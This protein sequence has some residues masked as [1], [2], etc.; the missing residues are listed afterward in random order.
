[1]NKNLVFLLSAIS[2]SMF[3]SSCEEDL[4]YDDDQYG[5]N[6][7]VVRSEIS[8]FFVR[9]IDYDQ[10]D[11]VIEV[12]TNG[13]G[14]EPERMTV[15]YNNNIA[16]ADFFRGG[17]L[18][19]SI[20]APL[21]EA[22]NVIESTATDAAGTEVAYQ[23][24]TYN[25]SDQI[26]SIAGRNAILNTEDSLVVVWTNDNATRFKR[27]VVPDVICDYYSGKEST[28]NVGLGNVIL[29]YMQVDGDIAQI[30]SKEL[31]KTYDLNGVI[32]GQ[33]IHFTYDLDSDDKVRK[34]FS[35]LSSG[36]PQQSTTIDYECE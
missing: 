5:S 27:Q 34:I 30:Y 8:D 7:M 12:S 16:F 29:L 14:M 2:F 24:F 25:P 35:S 36:N 22:G 33:P 21:N 9:T 15:T 32:V 10:L 19:F 1:M 11:R 4:P 6:C 17:Q 13:N 23:S 18:L 20:E 31:L 26:V 28:F 3:F